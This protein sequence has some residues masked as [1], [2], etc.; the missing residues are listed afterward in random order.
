[1]IS[2]LVN[3]SQITDHGK[4]NIALKEIWGLFVLKNITL[5]YQLKGL[6]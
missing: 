1:V 6:I 5:K 3:Q 2:Q 4:Q